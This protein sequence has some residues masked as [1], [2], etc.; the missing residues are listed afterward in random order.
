MARLIDSVGNVS[1]NGIVFPSAFHV[2]IQARPVYQQG[3]VARKYVNYTLTL[4]TVLT[5]TD[6][7]LSAAVTANQ[8]MGPNSA[9]Y[10]KLLTEPRKSL[11]FGGQGFGDFVINQAAN[12]VAIPVGYR[13][14]NDVA[15][16]PKPRLLVWEPVGS[17]RAAH[18]TWV[19]EFAIPECISD[20]ARSSGALLECTYETSFNVNQEGL[21]TRTI[22]ATLELAANARGFQFTDTVD[23]YV[24]R[25][26]PSTVPG[27]HRETHRH[28]SRDHRVLNITYTDT[29]IASDNAFPQGM[30]SMD[31][32][33]TVSSTFENEGFL[34]W[35]N[36]MSGTFRW[37]RGFTGAL[38]WSQFADIVR[39]RTSLIPQP[40]KGF[41]Q[42]NT[43]VPISR[44]NVPY[45]IQITEQLFNREAS[46]SIAW[47]TLTNIERLFES[48]GLFQPV[49]NVSWTK[50]HAS[51]YL[52]Q[53]PFGGSQLGETLDGVKI[54]DICSNQ[55]QSLADP[56][57]SNSPQKTYEPWFDYGC[58]KISPSTS[59]LNTGYPTVKVIT[60]AN[61]LPQIPAY[62]PPSTTVKAPEPSQTSSTVDFDPSKM[63]LT[64]T[65]QNYE[66]D[67]QVRDYNRYMIEVTGTVSRI[68]YEPYAPIFKSYGGV[69]L[70]LKDNEFTIKKVNG[71]FFPIYVLKYRQTY[72]LP[73]LPQGSALR[74]LKTD[75]GDG[76]R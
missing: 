36:T 21:L 48:T 73:R 33:H 8:D 70:V 3:D 28:V 29:E 53:S 65:P 6:P 45:S 12:Q 76:D 54:V 2:R 4:D 19:C 7:P 13:T 18:V 63:T 42:A 35:M 41:K 24:K 47:I 74:L 22:K 17:N 9:Y 72:Y 38:A 58:S 31:V 34:R 51:L 5:Y 66:P 64:G 10:R 20:S 60:E 43:W 50:W 69:D 55:Q 71:Q 15:F 32:S 30:V 40:A 1:Y 27:F 56:T 26:I 59:W 11:T 57:K 49:S 37:G 52:I 14:V 46:F 39:Q 67:Y 68:C 23:F 61:P 44:A 62:G 25:F 16:G 75:V